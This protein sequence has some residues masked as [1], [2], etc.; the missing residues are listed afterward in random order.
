MYAQ[1]YVQ[2]HRIGDRPPQNNTQSS[3]QV[4]AT[5]LIGMPPTPDPQYMSI[6]TGGLWTP[7]PDAQSSMVTSQ[8]S[9]TLSHDDRQH[10]PPPNVPKAHTRHNSSTPE[11]VENHV[12][13]SPADTPQFYPRFCT[14]SQLSGA[15]QSYSQPYTL[16]SQSQV[17]EDQVSMLP[18]CAPQGS[19]YLPHVQAVFTPPL[20]PP[21]HTGQVPMPQ[22]YLQSSTPP[23]RLLNDGEAH[24][25]PLDALADPSQ[26]SFPIG[27]SIEISASVRGQ[28]FQNQ[29]SVRTDP[30]PLATG[31]KWVRKR[32]CK[33]LPSAD[34]DGERVNPAVPAPT[35]TSTKST[36]RQPKNADYNPQR[37]PLCHFEQEISEREI[38]HAMKKWGI[39]KSFL[40]SIV[41]SP[42]AEEPK[43]C[44]RG[45]RER[46]EE[47]IREKL[48]EEVVEVLI[49]C[50]VSASML[51]N[52]KSGQGSTSQAVTSHI[53]SVQ[54]TG[55]S[56]PCLSDTH[57]TSSNVSFSLSH[58]PPAN[59]GSISG[60]GDTAPLFFG[61]NEMYSAGL[62]NPLASGVIPQPESA[63]GAVG[64]PF[65]S[66]P[67]FLDSYDPLQCVLNDADFFA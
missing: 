8:S 58:S 21:G 31:K 54:D 60:P 35:G 49:T 26:L 9:S 2:Y 7:L 61:Q 13:I 12:P 18:S 17:S 43:K 44:I 47:L 40:L 34:N 39:P 36:S 28:C 51:R 33:V 24:A 22:S 55:T 66:I 41:A 63:S 50:G 46:L 29:E 5:S 52:T 65:D 16:S 30:M 15:P 20:Q 64:W 23:S 42:K 67:P 6:S 19:S 57:E 53:Q 38:G 59:P 32:R 56:I 3:E 4:L 1:P 10:I 62:E 37:C 25:P 11:P 27:Q 14:S 48:D 45:I